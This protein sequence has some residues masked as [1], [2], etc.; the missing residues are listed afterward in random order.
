MH[1]VLVVDDEMPIRQWLEFCINRIEGYEVAGIAANGA[2]GFSLYRKMLPDIVITDIRMPVMDGLEMMQMIH[3]LNPSVYTV[4]LTSHED[5]EYARTSIKLGASEYILK[6]EITEE[7]LG[8]VLRAAS[9]SIG[10][11]AGSGVEKS[12]EELS[13]R[14]H[15]L[16]SL[17]L[18]QSTAL[19]SEAMMRQYEI[20]LEKG[21]YVALDVMT[22]GEEPIRI[23]LPEDDILTHALKIPV[24]LNHTVILGNLNREEGTG[25][26]R[27]MQRV[28]GYCGEIM[29]AIDCRIGCSDIYD[30]PGK[31]GLAMRQ[32]HERVKLGFY[33]SRERLFYTQPVGKYRTTNGE[34]YKILFGKELVNQNYKKAMAIK[35]QMMEEA[36]REEITDIDYLKKM[37]LFFATTL[38]HITK[39]DVEQ[40][41]RQ[42]A[43]IGKQ[44]MAAESL[45]VLDSILSG[46]FEEHGYA[47]ALSA[48]YSSAIRS[49]ISYMEERYAGPLTLSDVAAHAGLSSEYLSRLFKEETGVKFVVYLNNL[50]LKHALRLLETTNLKV[51]EVAEQVG[52]SN[53]SYF[54]TVF[55]KNFGQNPFDY[56]NNC[57][58]G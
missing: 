56:K 44:M 14:N 2:E 23:G 50:R 39:D 22:C 3:N 51:Y 11:A 57:R 18:G 54:S 48:D 46:V 43:D 25:E 9:E 41:E 6:T 20:P 24:D 55:K 52:Y 26:S 27:L 17:V 32:A 42:L 16:R 38:F 53:L 15:Y 4:V 37:Y 49:A 40:V 28:Y 13:N 21:Y 1:K 19:V 10:E 31:L 7:S 12:F 8:Q 58:Q 29:E 5:F 35:E 45:E 33:H 34:K 36:R 47:R 30:S